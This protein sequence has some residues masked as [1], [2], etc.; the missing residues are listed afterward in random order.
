M[1][2]LRSTLLVNGHS[3]L[4][5]NG[6]SK[7]MVNGHSELTNDKF[8]QCYSCLQIQIGMVSDDSSTSNDH[9]VRT[10]EWSYDYDQKVAQKFCGSPTTMVTLI[11]PS[12]GCVLFHKTCKWHMKKVS[13]WF[14]W[15]IPRTLQGHTWAVSND[16]EALIGWTTLGILHCTVWATN[17]GCQMML[18]LELARMA[19]KHWG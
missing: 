4:M 2:E 18:S 3:K 13:K 19:G 17:T 6:H 11:Y 10:R 1:S 9:E 5:V 14:P 15:L 12:S 16:V 8:C 7:L